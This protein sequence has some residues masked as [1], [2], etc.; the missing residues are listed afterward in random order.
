M[1]ALP[2]RTTGTRSRTPGGARPQRPTG[3]A[4]RCLRCAGS[5]TSSTRCT[6][7]GEHIRHKIHRFAL[8][9]GLL[10]DIHIHRSRYRLA[11]TT[12]LLYMLAYSLYYIIPSLT[13]DKFRKEYFPNITDGAISHRL[14]IKTLA[15]F[16]LISV[17]SDAQTKLPGPPLRGKYL[18]NAA[19]SHR[20][21]SDFTIKCSNCRLLS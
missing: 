18:L 1:L 11:T 13:D 20:K 4:R 21:C 12:A 16:R 15:V 6:C 8:V 10:Y 9:L 3:T 5:P 17:N 7:S 2:E 14:S 19:I